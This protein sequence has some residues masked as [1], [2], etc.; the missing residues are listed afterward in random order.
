MTR[1]IVQ[2]FVDLFG[3]SLLPV[4]DVIITKILGDGRCQVRGTFASLDKMIEL[5]V[6]RRQDKFDNVVKCL[7]ISS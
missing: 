6:K 7:K 1:D 2:R 3:G 4:K 5:C